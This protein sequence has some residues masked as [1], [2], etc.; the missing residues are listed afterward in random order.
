MVV[1]VAAG[2]NEGLTKRNSH[3]GMMVT[4]ISYA[5]IF[6]S[7]AFAFFAIFFYY[8]FRSLFLSALL[9]FFVTFFF[10]FSFF[11]PSSSVLMLAVYRVTCDGEA[12][13][14]FV[15]CAVDVGSAALV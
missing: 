9:H 4:C 8:F 13:Q 7:L 6:F 3:P 11:F 12:H 15:E 5:G 10:F 14:I 2:V 1:V